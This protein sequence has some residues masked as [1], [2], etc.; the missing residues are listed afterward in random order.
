[1]LP[2]L[3]TSQR[4]TIMAA[5][6]IGAIGVMSAAAASHAGE[7]R[8]LSAIAAICLAHGPVLLALGLASHGRVFNVSTLLMVFGTVVFAA[9]LGVREWLGHGLFPGAAPIG[10]VAMIAGWLA[11]VLAGAVSARK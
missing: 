2:H 7:S 9:D 5:G 1:M 6:L 4:L 3:Q 11:L 10:G 8:N